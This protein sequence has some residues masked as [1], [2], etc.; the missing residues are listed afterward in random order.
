M[1]VASLRNCWARP[2]QLCRCAIDS[3]NNGTFPRQN[4]IDYATKD[5]LPSPLHTHH[6]V[7]FRHACFTFSSERATA[8]LAVFLLVVVL[9]RLGT[10]TGGKRRETNV[11]S[12][13]VCH[14]A[15]W[16]T[17]ARDRPLAAC[18]VSCH[19]GH[20]GEAVPETPPVLSDRLR[21]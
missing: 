14:G 9:P 10:R 16:L 5:H 3:I 11:V 8:V 17:R 1:E 13:N 12:P 19:E 18:L 7:K 20:T 2:Q 15:P 21:D 6:E 4:N